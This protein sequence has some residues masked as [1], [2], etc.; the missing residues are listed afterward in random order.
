MM[1]IHILLLFQDVFDDFSPSLL[2]KP[3][4]KLSSLSS[5]LRPENW[6]ISFAPVARD[7]HW[8]NLQDHRGWLTT[9]KVFA[10]ILMLSIALFFTTPEV[11]VTQL[12]PLLNVIFGEDALQIPTFIKDFIPTLILL[13]VTALMPTVITWSVR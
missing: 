10:D 4:P 9:K 12:Q 1:N 2:N 8:K 7:I 5:S 13:G 11:I 3:N 6:R